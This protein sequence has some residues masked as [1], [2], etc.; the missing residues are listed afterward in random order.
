MAARRISPALLYGRGDGEHGGALDRDLGHANLE[1]VEEHVEPSAWVAVL[2]GGGNVYDKY[3]PLTSLRESLG[4]KG[5]G[6]T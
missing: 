4:I 5:S 6:E 2:L 3:L 1:V